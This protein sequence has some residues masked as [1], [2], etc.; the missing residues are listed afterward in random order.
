MI[1]IDA[2]FGRLTGGWGLAT[3]LKFETSEEILIA[4]RGSGDTYV[5]RHV[6]CEIMRMSTIIG[7]LFYPDIDALQREMLSIAPLG[8]WYLCHPNTLGGSN[9]E[10][11]ITIY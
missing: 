9:I 2:R 4:F 1:T 5:I 11:A 3:T 7:H 8:R 10:R 6:E